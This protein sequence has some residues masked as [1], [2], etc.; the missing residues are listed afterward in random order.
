VSEGGKNV[1]VVIKALDET[2][3]GFKS[4]RHHVEEFASEAKKLLLEAFA[5]F[6]VFEFFKTAVEKATEAEQSYVQL[7]NTLA[8][9]GVS[10]EKNREQ[11]EGTIKAL[12]KVANVRTDEAIKGFN[13]LVQ[14]SGDYAGSIKNLTLVADLAKA[15]HIEFNE[16]AE[17]VGRVMGGNTRV[18]K[19][20]GIVT[21]DATD[22]INQLRER[23]HGAAEAD[24][25]T[26]GGQV[27]YVKN[28][29]F[30][31][32]EAVGDVITGNN[33]LQ[34]TV[35][36]VGE[37]MVHLTE[38][39]E[40]NKATMGF[41]FTAIVAGVREAARAFKDLIVIAYETGNMIGNILSL[42]WGNPGD[43]EK[44]A[45]L[46]KEIEENNKKGTAAI[47][48]LAGGFDRLGESLATAATKEADGVKRTQAELD[49][50]AKRT[51]QRLAEREAA[52]QAA[53]D[54]KAKAEEDARNRLID[55]QLK[56]LGKAAELRE[57]RDRGIRE[58]AIAGLNLMESLARRELAG[59]ERTNATLH[60]RL[61]LEERLKTILDEKHKAGVS[62]IDPNSALETKD[63]SP[64]DALNRDF[65]AQLGT[66][67]QRLNQI[68]DD[69]KG[70]KVDLATLPHQSFLDKL[71]TDLGGVNSNLKQAKLSV[72]DLGE[73]F[74]NIT[75]GALSG[76]TQ[77][78]GESMAA[79]IT[80]SGNA[81]DAFKKSVGRALSAAAASEGKYWGAKSLAALGEGIFTADP[82]KFVAAAEFAAAS[83]AFYA[84][85]GIAG[86]AGG[87]GGGGAGG[88]SYSSNTQFQN[89]LG[90][91]GQGTLTVVWPG[92]S[93][94]SID[95]SD[96]MDQ[97]A[98][99]EMIKK[100]AG[101]RQVQF[102]FG[103]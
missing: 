27:E 2:L 88:G 61:I 97:D 70:F 75:V 34:G 64:G 41:W 91:V 69:F 93:K 16:A 15:K 68:R 22:G 103:S 38:S 78:V 21:H 55:T 37:W 43:K 87:G 54:K 84:V 57:F 40:K 23:L 30:D 86:G 63:L 13:T 79:L 81:G 39:I 94:S 45:A 36:S 66:A 73:S 32:L 101:N 12:Q 59:M 52:E 14:R 26:F 33:S 1:N 46:Y 44:R 90:G 3:P 35:K 62:A 74:A 48:D 25:K 11:I 85:S 92:T 82:S 17:L 4:A 28:R 10:Y 8:N 50:A 67:E 96:P 95:P 83:A 89:G 53:R 51:A 42:S 60:R 7:S 98:I 18:L 31:F 100:I 20:F 47:N 77:G 56:E 29:L 19:Q 99:V 102:T 65:A 6:T 58:Q 80:H 72:D 9:V 5:G 49:A 24:L 71:A 76:F